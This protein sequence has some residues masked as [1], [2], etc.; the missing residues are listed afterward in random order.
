MVI[1]RHYGRIAA[2]QKE[3]SLEH[4]SRLDE[5]MSDS[6]PADELQVR[7]SLE[8]AGVPADL[9]TSRTDL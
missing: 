9:V 7:C 6:L 8:T 1:A 5:A 3:S 2:L 4:D